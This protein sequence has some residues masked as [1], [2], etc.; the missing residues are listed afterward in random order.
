MT[1][2]QILSWAK[3]IY[4][5]R[6]DLEELSLGYGRE[7]WEQGLSQLSLGQRAIL[8][9]RIEQCGTLHEGSKKI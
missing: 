8:V 6:L 3:H 9:Q 5:A 7:K 1:N 2:E 4:Y